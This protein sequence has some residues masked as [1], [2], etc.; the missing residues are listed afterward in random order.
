VF[1]T[2]LP[3]AGT[4]LLLEILA[5][6]PGFAAH[7]YRDMPFV[8]APVL[9]AGLSGGFHK[10]PSLEER[11]H[12]D[13]MKVG[14]DSPEAFEEILWRAYWPK[15]YAADRILL[16]SP[17]D[18][19][20]E[21][22]RLFTDHLKKIITLRCPL[23]AAETRYVSKNNANIAR[24]PLLKKL[25][26]DCLI[27]VPVREPID[28]AGSLLR[29]HLRFGA[30]HAK[31]PFSKQYM[32]DIGHL[33]FGA[34]HRPL[35]FDGMEG[36]SERYEISSWDYWIAYWVRAFRHIIRYEKDIAVVSYERLC[37]GDAAVIA[38]LG[39]RIEVDP[40]ELASAVGDR[41]HPPPRYEAEARVQDKRLLDE[42]RALHQE[43]MEVAV[44]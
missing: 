10:T 32:E 30:L 35:Q 27:L 14:Y 18:D 37:T 1:I 5:D 26:A 15:K 42:A 36:L 34:L 22:R 40:T 23:Q 41:L 24:I 31:D 39:E 9:W 8:L 29:Q 13:G 17:E 21:F 16:W 28:H 44:F 7:C 12:G 43:L 19:P 3:R 25:F 38:A 4:T 33:E 6:V 20:D 11:A 2:S